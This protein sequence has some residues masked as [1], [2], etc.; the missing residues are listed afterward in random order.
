MQ[1]LMRRPEI[2]K[3]ILLGPPAGKY[4]FNFLAPCP[5]SG[6]IFSGEKDILIDHNILGS[7][8]K[9]LNEQ[10]NIKVKHESIKGSDHF[11]TNHET[12]IIQKINNYIKT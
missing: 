1:L 5:A 7:L 4:D 3:F 10:E 11:F 9:K 12:S 6:V 2:T 8:V